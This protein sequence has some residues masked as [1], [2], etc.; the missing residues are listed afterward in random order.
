[1]KSTF[2]ILFYLNTSKRKKSGLCPVMGRIT[3]DGGVAQFSIK[4]DVYPSDW[5][6]KN[7][8]VKGKS[9]ENVELNRKIE[10]TE[11]AITKI[12]ARAVDIAG[13]VTAQQ[14]K[15]ELTGVTKKSEN[16]LELFKEHNDEYKKRVGIDR[17][18]VSYNWYKNT[19]CHLSRFIL[20]EYGM[21]D[22]PLKQLDMLFIDKYDLYLRV[23]A[24]LSSNTIVGHI[25]NLKKIIT[26]AINQRI[27]P[28]DP[29][30]EYVKSQIKR[31]Y[32]HIT[33]EELQRLLSTPIKSKPVGYVRDMF[34]FSC[35]T[36]L[37]FADM[38]Q[39]SEKHLRKLPNGRI[40]IEIPRCKT[41]VQSNIRLLDIPLAIIE[42]YH[43]ERK[44]DLLF[45]ISNSSSVSKSL[46]KI[47][48]LCNIEHL[49]FHMA[50]HTFATLICLS[51]GVSMEALSKMMGHSS[52]QS[53][54]IYAEITGQKIGKDMK[55]LAARIE[56]K[57]AINHLPAE[58]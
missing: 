1:M 30:S 41:E 5:D 34:V 26:R 39:L 13:F 19:Y 23:D 18:K 35:F 29:F 43:L 44:S 32:Q 52:I 4:A 51:N 7:G 45:N 50:R 9:R 16:L 53:T 27:I 33:K 8:R 12:Y 42:K 3:V 47:A 14:I 15:N 25:I 57:Y 24:G 37:A 28:N 31:K 54:Q 21:N 56:G 58:T 48:K 2:K 49:H 6:A 55:K 22:Y 40:R 46:R 20:S 17:E 10:Q 36:G 11:E 38:R